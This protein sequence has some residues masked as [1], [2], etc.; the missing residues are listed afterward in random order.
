MTILI[1]AAV[2]AVTLLVVVGVAL[3][4]Y[5]KRIPIGHVIAVEIPLKRSADEV[6]DLIADVPG[7]VRWAPKVKSVDALEPRD[8]KPV[9]RMRVDR[10]AFT[11]VAGVVEPRRALMLTIVDD[12]MFRGTWTWTIAPTPQ[13][14]TVR[15]TE[16]GEISSALARAMVRVTGMQDKFLVLNLSG[17]AKH[18][19]TE[20]RPQR[21]A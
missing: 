9:Y 8:G 4:L 13:G 21:V 11:I 18:F 7:H 20:V 19:G 5:G 15:L 6:Y 10:Q 12:K 17:M 16:R 3:L 1:Y 2:A 14:C